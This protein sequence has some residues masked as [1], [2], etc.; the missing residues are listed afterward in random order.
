[1]ITDQGKLR[2][3][4]QCNILAFVELLG[5]LTLSLQKANTFL[6]I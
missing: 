3:S 4:K 6:Y 2:N 1:M 5:H